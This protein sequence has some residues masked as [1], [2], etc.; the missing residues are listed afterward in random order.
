MK[1]FLSRFA[2][3]LLL[4]LLL[5]ACAE[6]PPGEP[7]DVFI[8]MYYAYLNAPTIGRNLLGERQYAD[9]MAGLKPGE[10]AIAVM[11]NGVYSFKGTAYVHGGMFDRIQLVQGERTVSFRDADYER[12]DDP[13]LPGM[14]GFTERGI[15]TVRSDAR[16]DPGDVED[17]KDIIKTVKF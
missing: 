13:V 5:P 4:L 8:D 10:H 17:F 6:L 11:A 3:L 16:L 15:F 12:L 2:P 1:T 9:L 14:P 7:C